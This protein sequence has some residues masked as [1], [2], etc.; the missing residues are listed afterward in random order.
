[1]SAKSN[2]SEDKVKK[3]KIAKIPENL[4]NLNVNEGKSF[5]KICKKIS[6]IN[7]KNMNLQFSDGSNKLGKSMF[8]ISNYVHN[9]QLIFQKK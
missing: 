8:C 2:S 4:D 6:K 5:L 3:N 9:F 7:F 1:M